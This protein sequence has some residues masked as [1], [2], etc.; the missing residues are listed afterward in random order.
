MDHARKLRNIPHFS[1]VNKRL[2]KLEIDINEQVGNDIIIALDSTGIK[3][4][5][6]GEWMQIHLKNTQPASIR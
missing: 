4:A 6:L 1:T 3:L 2:N 5:N